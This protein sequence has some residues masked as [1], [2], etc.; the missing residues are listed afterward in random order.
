MSPYRRWRLITVTILLGVAAIVVGVL[1]VAAL[2]NEDEPTVAGAPS[3]DDLT[4]DPEEHIG[5]TVTV[6]AN[7]ARLLTREAFTIGPTISAA[8]ISS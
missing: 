7:V 1:A 4:T 5:K 3:F 2:T 6:T 8:A